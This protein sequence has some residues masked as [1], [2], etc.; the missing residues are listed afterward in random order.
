MPGQKKLLIIRSAGFQQLDSNLASIKQHFPGRELHLLTHEH[1][2][3]LAAKY[4]DISC[5]RIYPYEGSFNHNQ[6]IPGQESWKYDAVAVLVANISGA[7]FA[8]V[9]SF[10]A[11]LNEGELYL[12]NLVGEI[13]HLQPNDLAALKHR[14]FYCRLSG[15]ILGAVL[16]IA[17]AAWFALCLSFFRLLSP[18]EKKKAIS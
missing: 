2:R 14:D 3:K 8:N 4:K 1:G 11:S 15:V 5:I 13:R 6:L 12:C 9:L 17:C 7:G 18:H 10:A 16:G